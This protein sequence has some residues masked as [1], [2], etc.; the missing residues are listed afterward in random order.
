MKW[1]NV[2]GNIHL[3]FKEIAV[4]R[5]LGDLDEEG[6]NKVSR[7]VSSLIKFIFNN[8]QLLRCVDP[9]APN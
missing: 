2:C 3:A 4:A 6:Y 1:Q 8:V 9:R 5:A 7:I